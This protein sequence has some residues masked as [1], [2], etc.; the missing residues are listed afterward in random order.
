[1][2]YTN[3]HFNSENIAGHL[4][5]LAVG[6]LYA[7]IERPGVPLIIVVGLSMGLSFSCRFQMGFAIAGLLIVA[8]LAAALA[9]CC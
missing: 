9:G 4:M 1:M 5:L 7:R 2:L 3:T 6:L 8:A